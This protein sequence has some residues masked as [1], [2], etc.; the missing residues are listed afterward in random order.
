MVP[1]LEAGLPTSGICR[2]FPRDLVYG[3]LKHQG[4]ALPNLYTVQGIENI[5]TV[6]EFG[7]NMKTLTGQLLKGNVEALQLELGVGTP[8]FVKEF[9]RYGTLVTSSWTQHTW[10]WLHT[11][12]VHIEDQVGRRR[13]HKYDANIRDS[14]LVAANR[15]RLYLRVVTLADISDGLGDH[16]TD[17]AWLGHRDTDRPQY[18][19]WPP[20]GY[21]T[22]IAR[23]IMNGHL[24]GIPA[25]AIGPY[26]ARLLHK[27]STYQITLALYRWHWVHG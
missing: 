8:V 19:E 9:W 15:C 23:N 5:L 1:V 2:P 3:P 11:K 18:Y 24:K 14:E 21:P 6:M 12:G 20:Q 27:H 26:D 4:L 16:V 25:A 17:A 10:Q 7:Y 22:P 13:G